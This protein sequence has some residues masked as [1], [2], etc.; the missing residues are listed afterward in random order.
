MG[1]PDYV[2]LSKP[3]TKGQIAWGSI[4]WE[5]QNSQIHGDRKYNGDYQGQKGGENREL[6]FTGD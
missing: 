1:E 2:M 4:V 3:I 5:S 6:Q